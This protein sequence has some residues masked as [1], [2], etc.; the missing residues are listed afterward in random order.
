MCLWSD[1]FVFWKTEHIKVCINRTEKKEWKTS[2][3]TLH[4]LLLRSLADVLACHG[5]LSLAF[6]QG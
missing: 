6:L 4:M 2:S 3:R 5:L 1:S